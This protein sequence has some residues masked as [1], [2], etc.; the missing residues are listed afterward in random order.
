MKIK[1][2]ATNVTIQ[3]SIEETEKLRNAMRHVW[4]EANE[5]LEEQEYAD[6]LDLI[7]ETFVALGDVID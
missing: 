5:D 7:F 3:L 4:N 2:T 1:K 6:N